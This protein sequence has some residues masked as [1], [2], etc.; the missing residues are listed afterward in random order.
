[1]R[2]RFFIGL[3]LAADLF[4]CAT[5]AL[6]V[7]CDVASIQSIAPSNSKITSAVE[8]TSGAIPYCQINA[9]IT[10]DATLGDVIHYEVG[11][12]D[13]S[14]WN[15]RFL[16]AG[17]AGL[18]GSIP[19]DLSSLQGSYA[20]AAT[21]TGHT[22]ANRD[23]SWALNNTPAVLDFEY[24]AVHESAVAAEQILSGY[25]G[26]PA[27]HSYFAGCST[28]GRQGLVEAENYPT[29]FDGIAAGDPAIGQNYL[30]F[31]ANAQAILSPNS[32]LDSAAITLLNQ[33][34]LTQCDGLDGVVD[35]LIQNPAACAFNPAALLCSPGQTTGCL[36]A[37]QIAAVNKIYQGPVDTAGATLYPGLSISD[38]AQS[39]PADAGWPQMITGCPQSSCKLPSFTGAEPWAGFPLTP[40]QWAA[41]D[42]FY[43]Y[44]ISNNPNLD[45][46]TISFS[47]QVQLSAI[48]SRTASLGGEG[49]NAD[50]TP[51][52]TSGH[53]LLMY[54]GW[55]DPVFSPYVS[56]NYYNNVQATLGSNTADSIRLFMAPGMHHCQ[57]FGP[58]PNSFDAVSA[59]VSWV[60]QG[61]VPEGIVA[62]H[63]I[64]DNPTAPID[65]T[66]PL[67]AYPELAIYDDVGPVNDASSWSCSATNR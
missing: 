59:L 57:G 26:N 31:N 35:G 3:F 15:S 34:V 18:A 11:L 21:D 32:Y 9:S 37:G 14:Y 24:R 55:S 64:N 19:F 10:T 54:H 62:S 39:A 13:S 47:N 53:K 63:H 58:G 60:E 36:T 5:R 22:G 46:K 20:V 56:V 25:Y 17:N 61:V 16:F 48:T 49:M 4:I 38:P 40:T 67:C 66:M 28:G 65:R 43:K 50:L 51:F 2:P 1:M 29:D 52:V 45:T 7:S 6:A 12:P 27:Y 44:F 8:T 33:A 30:A 42:G 23:A 41:Q